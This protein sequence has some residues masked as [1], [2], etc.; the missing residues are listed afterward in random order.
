MSSIETLKAI[1][2]LEEQ[3]RKIIAEANEKA[4]KLGITEGMKVID[5]FALIA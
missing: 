1:R 4:K 2:D 5:A 3:A